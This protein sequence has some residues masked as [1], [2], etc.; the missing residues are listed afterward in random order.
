LFIKQEEDEVVDGE[1]EGETIDFM[2]RPIC[3]KRRLE[4]ETQE[5]CRGGF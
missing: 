3:F 5:A 4:E 2:G 1:K